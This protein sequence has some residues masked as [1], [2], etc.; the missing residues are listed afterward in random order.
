MKFGSGSMLTTA[1]AGVL[2]PNEDAA[3]AIGEESSVAARSEF[4]RGADAVW[5][6]RALRAEVEATVAH[7]VAE[8]EYLSYRIYSNNEVRNRKKHAE[9]TKRI[10]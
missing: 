1:L 6:S 10:Q 3:N 9:H 5:R 4:R 7:A 2:K 8:A